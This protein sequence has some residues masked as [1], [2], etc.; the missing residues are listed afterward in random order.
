MNALLPSRELE[1]WLL[2][3]GMPS[4]AV[5]GVGIAG[6]P[7]PHALEREGG[8]I[9]AAKYSW[10][11]A[12]TSLQEE[13]RKETCSCSIFQPSVSRVPGYPSRAVTPTLTAR[14]L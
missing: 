4:L 5:P 8:C 6:V 1:L 7:F 3:L 11:I 10:S 14:S 13:D 9:L 2:Y 12:L